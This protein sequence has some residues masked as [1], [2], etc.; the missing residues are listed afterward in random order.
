[1]YSLLGLVAM[2]AMY[3]F[4]KNVFLSKNKSQWLLFGIILGLGYNLHHFFFFIPLIQ[5]IFLLITF[6]QNHPI[7]RNWA[8]S[9][10]G[11]GLLL[12]PWILVV[13][14]W[15]NFYGRR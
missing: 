11:A 12:L 4:S 1:M 14:D 13:L 2:G 15:G 9:V 3:Y 6:K 7:F 5:F 10:L 8:I